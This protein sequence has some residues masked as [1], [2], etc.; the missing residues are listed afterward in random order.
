MEKTTRYWPDWKYE[1]PDELLAS[2]DEYHILKVPLLGQHYPGGPQDWCGRTSSSMAFNYYQ[3]VQGGAESKFITHW[4]GG[5]PGNFV[6]LRYPGGQRAFHT[7]P[8]KGSAT[9]NVSGYSV[10]G[11]TKDGGDGFV[12]Q[13]PADFDAAVEKGALHT[14]EVLGFRPGVL[15]PYDEPNRQARAAE[16][17]S[18]PQ[19]IASRLETILQALTSNNPVILYSGFSLTLG[20]PVHLI[21]IVGYAYVTDDTGRHLWLVVADPATQANKISSGMLTPPLPKEPTDLAGLKS[22]SGTHDLIRVIPGAWDNAKGSLVMIRARKLFEDNRLST[23][24]GDLYMDYCE[25]DRKGGTFL[26]SHR[27]TPVPPEL[28]YTNVMRSVAFPFDDKKERFRPSNVYIHTESAGAGLFPIGSQRNLHSGIH[29]ESSRFAPAGKAVRCFA[30]GYVVAVRMVKALPTPPGDKDAKKDEENPGVQSN[31]LAQELAG[32]HN[33]FILVR[34]DVEEFIPKKAGGAG[35]SEPERFCF[36]SLYMHLVPPDWN[37]VTTY[38]DVAWLKTLA[39]R[40]GCVA[41][42]DPQHPSYQQVKWLQGA[43][44]GQNGPGELAQLRGGKL[45]TMGAGLG[46]PQSL[47]LGAPKEDLIRAVWKKPDQDL[48]ELH[49]ALRNGEIVTIPHPYLKVRA[50]ELL[51]YIDSKSRDGEGFLHWEVF[52]PSS[53][54][55]LKEFLEFAEDKLKLGRGF[56]KFYEETD[57]PNNVFDPPA[58]SGKEGELDE[59][60]KLAPASK[61]LGEQERQAL[62]SFQTSYDA[63]VLQRLLSSPKGLAF[64]EEEEP[65]ST[66][67]DYPAEVSLENFKNCMP[68]GSYKLK[69]TFE[70]GGAEQVVPYDGKQASVRIRVPAKAKKICVEPEGFFIQP[71][72]GSDP[73]ALTK[74]VKHFRNLASVRWRNVILRHVNDWSEKGIAEQLKAHLAMRGK[75]QIG[76]RLLDNADPKKTEQDIQELA[77]SVAW[78]GHSSE[79]AVLGPEEQGEPLFAGSPSN[80]EQ[81]PDDTFLD[82][83]NPVTVAWVLMLL[84]RH[85]FI[86]F[87]DK[88]VWRSEDMKKVAACGWL[89]ARAKHA[90]LRMGEH[91]TACAVQRGNG[92]EPVALKMSG[93][94]PLTLGDGKFV[95]GL[96]V[97]PVEFPAWGKWVLDKPG[98]D[99]LGSLAVEG[100][101]PTLLKAPSDQT[102]SDTQSAEDP[103]GPVKLPDGKRTWRVAFR[104]NCPRF[105]RGWITLRGWQ[106]DA[107]AEIPKETSQYTLEMAIPIEARED[108]AFN[109]QAG[110]AIIDGFVQQGTV[111]DVSTYITQHFTYKA[112]LDAVKKPGPNAPPAAA[113]SVPKLAWEL[114]EAVERVQDEYSSRQRLTLS[115]LS[116]NGLSLLLKGTDAARLKTAVDKVMGTGWI[117]STEEEAKGAIRIKVAPPEQSKNAGEVVIEFNPSAAFSELRKNLAPGQQ[118]AVQLGCFFPN[119]GGALDKRL[120]PADTVGSK[121]TQ[122]KLAELKSL[123]QAGYLEQW[124]TAG[125]EVLHKPGF[126]KPTWRLTTTGIKLSVELVGADW[127]FWNAATPVLNVGKGSLDSIKNNPCKI[128]A[129]KGEPLRAVRDVEFSQVKGATLAIMAEA[130][131]KAVPF[132]L[133]KID[134]ANSETIAYDVRPSA[135]LEIK[136]KAGEEYTRLIELT[137]QAVTLAQT[138]KLEFFNP[139]APVNPKK[140]GSE[141]LKLAPTSLRYKQPRKGLV[142]AIEQDGVL[143]AEVELRDVADALRRAGGKKCKVRVVPTDSAL[144]GACGKEQALDIPEELLP[145]EPKQEPPRDE[146]VGTRLSNPPLESSTDTAGH[147]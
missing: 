76:D 135:S 10:Y 125:A 54:G 18:S 59:L 46:L 36:Y 139:E 110:F 80:D 66:E 34:H 111:K 100:L 113:G 117:D 95:E 140:P 3:L 123:A 40:D 26:Y 89:P 70:P 60:L 37:D 42:V 129:A 98:G 82:H 23:V 20:A 49:D 124:S 73:D 136:P 16:I 50:G 15:L 103:L 57:K 52:A 62:K 1:L 43:P 27:W 128:V 145:T 9:S 2:L 75:L 97:Q 21:L 131:K 19:H 137:T 78:W 11:T 96:F 109:E 35:G 41:V 25:S 121:P 30:P 71:G 116:E 94:V 133:E 127:S 61:H 12:A 63:R 115:A 126:G 39:R 88:P 53:T 108:T 119:G 138:F 48:K 90:P 72:G 68:P 38:Q 14:G 132:E 74:D 118:L 86:R 8:V 33:S 106:G 147:T 93:A 4:N 5:T 102:E 56:F 87:T 55:Q 144:K 77:K 6:D 64:A 104:R 28:L 99:A 47:D 17:A 31:T 67:P 69:F 83:A 105:L 65:S 91:I 141:V 122:V 79:K 84:G 51:G 58:V 114:V 146:S 32:N 112:F 107:K 24:R 101:R 130:R 134:V 81:L 22:L 120:L 142:G 7:V 85:S 143:R 29:L 45:N 92:G 13:P 44:E